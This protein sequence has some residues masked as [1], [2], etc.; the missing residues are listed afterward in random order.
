MKARLVL[1]SFIIQ[2]L[3]SGQAVFTD[4]VLSSIRALPAT[5]QITHVYAVADAHSGVS[6][7]ESRQLAE[8]GLAMALEQDHRDNIMEGYLL[9]GRLALHSPDF[10]QAEALFSQVLDMSET[11]RD[12]PVIMKAKLGLTQSAG[13]Q[14]RLPEERKL[15][16]EVLDLAR[17]S[18]DS[19][20]LAR[21]RMRM[22]INAEKQSM[23]EEALT[24]YY[25]AMSTFERLGDRFRVGTVHTNI[26]M[27]MLRLNR[28]AAA[29]AEFETA[30]E[31]SRT[32]DDT[33][34]IMINLL[35]IGV[36][37]QKLKQFDQASAAYAQSMQ[38]ATAM[39]AWADI[40]ILT[41]NL[42]TVAMQQGRYDDALAYLKRA[43]AIKDSIG[44]GNDLPHTVNSLAEVYMHLGD[45]DR[46]I[47]KA[48]QA[49]T[50]SLQYSRRDQLSFAYS[51]LAKAYAAQSRY[52]LAY[53]Y[54]QLHKQLSDS[55]YSQESDQAVSDLK[56]RYETAIKE[57]QIEKLTA[58]NRRRKTAQLVYSGIALLVLIAGCA[59]VYALHVRRTRDKML[60][61]KER[62]LH[63]LQNRFF[64]NISHEFRTPL[65]LILGPVHALLRKW[66]DSEDEPALRTI[67]KNADRLL[68]LINQ[69]LDLTRLDM[70]RMELSKEWLDATRV[71]RGICSSFDSLAEERDIRYRYEIGEALV[72]HAD[73]RRFEVVSTN[74]ITN[75][76][77]FTPDGGSITVTAGIQSPDRSFVLQVRDSGRGIPE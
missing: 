12:L 67:R 3:V 33:E 24:L 11:P 8:A 6:L 57:S 1:I 42:G 26:G 46:A 47:R 37:H 10:Q 70:K 22:G 15:L 14:G 59:I 53:T 49:V 54:L 31:I 13:A 52:P 63:E 45:Y 71:I 25:Q 7:P 74:L 65:T 36:V 5:Q 30:M 35:N 32:E 17:A 20:M 68:H 38:M 56:I 19:I 48:H 39:G 44:L 50:L 34:G 23:F 28:Y 41:G 60:L 18:G 75:A 27:T 4:S 2:H 21:V 72:I 29:L 64:A 76:F 73:Q 51:S 9:L 61:A 66:K 77:K 43:E 62:E 55:I 16:E 40:A 69:I 58:E